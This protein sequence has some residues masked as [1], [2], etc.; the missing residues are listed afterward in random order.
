MLVVPGV[1][2]VSD[3]LSGLGSGDIPAVVDPFQLEGGEERL[4]GGVVQG[5]AY[6][7]HGLDDPQP[8]A[9]FGE[10]FG[11]VLRASV[12]VENHSLDGS[13]SGGD[14]HVHR[15]FGQLGGGITVTKPGSTDGFG[16]WWGVNAVKCLSDLGK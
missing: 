7:S 5:G 14:G 15:G 8:R 1:D 9:G 10:R 13:A 3:V 2:P 16:G 11:V 12:G 6:S 4:G